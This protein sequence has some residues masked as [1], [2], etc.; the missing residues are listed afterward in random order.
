MILRNIDMLFIDVGYTICYPLTGDWRY[1]KKLIEHVGI[2][3]FSKIPDVR[4]KEAATLSVEYLFSNHCISTME[5]EY[6]QNITAYSIIAQ[7][8]PE[9]MLS[10]DDIRI[11]AEDRT[12]NMDNYVFYPNAL[13]KIKEL[14]G[15]VRISIISDAWPSSRLLLKKAGIW[16]YIFTCTLSS[17]LGVCKPSRAIYEKALYDS[18]ATPQKS[19]FIDD[20]EP[21]LFAAASMGIN[22]IKIQTVDKSVS[23]FPTILDIS[24]I[25]IF[26]KNGEYN[27]N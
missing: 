14:S 21:N 3:R 9:L 12:Y 11:I 10:N 15:M 17:D 23:S 20:Y 5:E 27:D 26:N 6:E 19:Y 25:Q 24:E 16:E 1:T 18:K 13:S 22:P 7:Q 4:K 2:E 8:L